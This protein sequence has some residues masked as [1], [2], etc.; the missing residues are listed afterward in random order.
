VREA[1]DCAGQTW[2]SVLS[3]CLSSAVAREAL[4]LLSPKATKSAFT[5][6]PRY[7]GQW[8]TAPSVDSVPVRGKYERPSV[9]YRLLH[10]ESDMRSSSLGLVR[11]PTSGLRIL[12]Y[13]SLSPPRTFVEMQFPLCDILVRIYVILLLRILNRACRKTPLRAAG[14]I[15]AYL[16]PLD[17]SGFGSSVCPDVFSPHLLTRTRSRISLFRLKE[18]RDRG[19]A[20]SSVCHRRSLGLLNPY[21]SVFRVPMMPSVLPRSL[22]TV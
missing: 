19:P 11:Y 17:E 13:V 14:G 16:F 21:L 12:Q 18:R 15:L 3:F 7:S 9:V 2:S 6:Y 8:P 20:I 4:S 1:D 10:A 5:P 22:L